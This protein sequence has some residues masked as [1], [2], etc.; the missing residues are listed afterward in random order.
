[1]Y[2]YWRPPVSAPQEPYIATDG[3][4]TSDDSNGKFASLKGRFQAAIANTRTWP[5]IQPVDATH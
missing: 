1:M 4:F 5:W 2:G 3:F